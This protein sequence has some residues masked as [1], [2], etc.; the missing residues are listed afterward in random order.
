MTTCVPAASRSPPPGCRRA[1]RSAR[2]SNSATVGQDDGV[3]VDACDGPGVGD[4]VGGHGDR[5]GCRRHHR[6]PRCWRGGDGSVA[7][8]TAE[9]DWSHRPYRHVPAGPDAIE[10]DLPAICTTRPLT[11]NGTVAGSATTY[12]PFWYVTA[13]PF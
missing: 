12:A 11:S 13:R 2:W 4:G 1:S 3:R 9:R 7:L 10:R 8:T 6:R 5:S